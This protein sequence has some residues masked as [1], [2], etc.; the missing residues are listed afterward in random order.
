MQ[1][2]QTHSGSTTAVDR[3]G[4]TALASARH[5]SP[6]LATYP[7]AGSHAAMPVELRQKSSAQTGPHAFATG[8]GAAAAVHAGAVDRSQWPEYQPRRVPVSKNTPRRWSSHR[9]RWTR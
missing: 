9:C 7:A 4:A 8:A 2:C 3:R 5:R 6:P 1:L